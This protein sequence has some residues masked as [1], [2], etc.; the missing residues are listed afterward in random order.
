MFFLLIFLQDRLMNLFQWNFWVLCLCHPIRLFQPT[1]L[2]T[3]EIF[4]NLPV[5]YFGRNLPASPFILLSPSI[6]NSRLLLFIRALLTYLKKKKKIP[7]RY[8]I[9]NSFVY[10]ELYKNALFIFQ[11]V[12]FP[13]KC[14]YCTVNFTTEIY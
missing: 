13:Q 12:D 10:I 7:R 14:S 1:L 5:Y 11:D 3:S 2:L 4:A 9:N 6:W 8:K